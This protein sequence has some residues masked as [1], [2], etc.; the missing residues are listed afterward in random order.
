MLYIDKVNLFYL[1]F[2]FQG[3]STWDVS[4]IPGS[5]DII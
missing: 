3:V 1:L 2:I 4:D 5:H